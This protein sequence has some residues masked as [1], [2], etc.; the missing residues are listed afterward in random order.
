[1]Y[2]HLKMSRMNTQQGRAST[3]S[4]PNSNESCRLCKP[5]SR[6]THCTP[7]DSLGRLPRI[8]WLRHCIVS[9]WVIGRKYCSWEGKRRIALWFLIAHNLLVRWNTTVTG[10]TKILIAACNASRWTDKACLEIGVS[11]VASCADNGSSV[12]C[13]EKA[14]EDHHFLHS[15]Y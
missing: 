1:M 8:A 12:D 4:K 5:Y 13:Y 6:S 9:R 3:H 7:P 10:T 2:T 14:W 15:Y 11:I